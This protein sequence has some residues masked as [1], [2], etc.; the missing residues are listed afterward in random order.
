MIGIR[1][2][3]FCSNFQETVQS[4]AIFLILDRTV[5]L[6]FQEETYSWTKPV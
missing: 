2:V 5:N 6:G 3:F 1:G 4:F